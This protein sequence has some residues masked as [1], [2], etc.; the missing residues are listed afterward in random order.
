[1]DE[2]LGLSKGKEIS[3]HGMSFSVFQQKATTTT[4]GDSAL[5]KD[6]N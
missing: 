2:F 3:F 6:D 5:R 1:L 4:E